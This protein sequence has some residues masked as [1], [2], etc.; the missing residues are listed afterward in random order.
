MFLPLSWHKSTTFGTHASIVLSQMRFSSCF[1]MGLELRMR[2]ARWQNNCA[3]CRPWVV[4]TWHH[5]DVKEASWVRRPHHS[6][7]TNFLSSIVYTHIF[8]PLYVSQHKAD[9]LSVTRSWCTSGCNECNSCVKRKLITRIAPPNPP[10]D[11]LHSYLLG[12]HEVSRQDGVTLPF[13]TRQVFGGYGSL[14]AVEMSLYLGHWHL[15]VPH[16]TELWQA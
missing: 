9:Y 3:W 1:V 4:S 7:R 14:Y 5:S 6:T 12:I 10:M 11:Q 15:Y 8:L 2:L 16:H 13:V